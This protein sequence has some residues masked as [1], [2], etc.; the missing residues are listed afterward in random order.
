MRLRREVRG[1][2]AEAMLLLGDTLPP[3]GW[4]LLPLDRNQPSSRRAL[5]SYLPATL[6]G[7][8]ALA[9]R[10]IVASWSDVA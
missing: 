1:D 9:S 7:V 2:D 5:Q 6:A 8:P 4:R 3:A 10:R